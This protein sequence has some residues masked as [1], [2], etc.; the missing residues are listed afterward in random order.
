[1]STAFVRPSTANAPKLNTFMGQIIAMT[2]TRDAKVPTVVEGE[3]RLTQAAEAYIISVDLEANEAMGRGTTLVFPQ[4]LQQTLRNSKG[5]Y[6]LG[7][8][9]RTERDNGFSLITLEDLSEEDHDAAV[10]L[11][12]EGYFLPPVSTDD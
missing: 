9:T 7:R 5:Q 8:L 11:I 1:M 6:I 3:S 2:W 12:S 4:V 10:V